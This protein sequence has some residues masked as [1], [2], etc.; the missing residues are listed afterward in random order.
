MNLLKRTNALRGQLNVDPVE[1]IDLETATTMVGSL[2]RV[3]REHAHRYY[4]LDDPIIADPEYDV[5]FRALQQIEQKFPGLESPD[6]PT[7]RVGGTPLDRF[8]RHR[9]PEPLLSLSNAFNAEDLEAWYDRC[10]RMLAQAGIED[11]PSLTVEPKIDGIA[12]ALT[13]I[14]G[15]LETGATRGNGLEG[16][17]ATAQ[18]R[19]IQ[20]VPLRIP[21]D[22][23]TIVPDRIEVRGEAYMRLADFDKMNEAQ[24]AKGEKQYANPRNSTAGSIRQL[25]PKIT[26][27]RPIRFFAYSSQQKPQQETQFESLQQ[28]ATFGF[29]INDRI[30]RFGGI[31][32]VGQYCLDWIDHRDSLPYEIDGVVV[33]I[34]AFALQQILGS[35]AHAPRWAIAFKFPAQEA[36]TRLNEIVLSVGRTGAV[37]PVAM[38]EPVHVA[39]VTVSKATLHNEDYVLSRDIREG[40]LVTIKRAGDVIPQVIAPIESERP[41]SAETWKMASACPA[42]GEQISRAE[43]D[44]D[45]YCINGACPAQR[46]RSI[47]HFAMRG[48]MDIDGFGEKLAQQLVDSSMVTSVADIYTL[49]LE[50]LLGLEGFG[51]KKAENLLQGIEQSKSRPLGRLI[52][53]LGIRFVGGT[54]ADL[55][56]SAVNSLDALLRMSADELITIDG[57]GPE[58]AGS[59]VAWSAV[60][61]NV[62][63][64]ESLNDAGVNTMRLAEEAPPEGEAPLSGLTFVLTGTLPSL[65]RKQAGDLIKRAG[66]RVVGS[67]SA[68]TSYVVAGASAGSKATKGADLGIRTIDETELLE[69]VNT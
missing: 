7:H 36:T 14:D 66:G 65:T 69:L 4:V 43:G 16:E 3:L 6:S 38:L 1:T 20:D 51:Q 2:R 53:G 54:I 19:T 31:A 37:K 24:V 52:F 28:L 10:C 17:N 26:A 15:Q 41:E 13:Y 25:D 35:V 64:V 63:L 60:Q 32:E 29:A 62:L 9:H 59:V 61:A 48:A 47:E 44:A 55:L 11:V 8:E 40:D 49:T 56:V 5:L 27:S 21:V 42:C 50:N 58:I 34:D 33:K 22:G 67:V 23:S 45:Y 12:L 68:S 46:I 18:V 39:G 30:E 57:I